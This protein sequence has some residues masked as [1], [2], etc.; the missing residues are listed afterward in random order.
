MLTLDKPRY[1]PSLG[2]WP[3][4]PYETTSTPKIVAFVQPPGQ[5]WSGMEIT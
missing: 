3:L 5:V 2:S 1:D 4:C